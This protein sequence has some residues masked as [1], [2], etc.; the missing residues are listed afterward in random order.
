MSSPLT[1]VLGT[2]SK[3]SV[4]STVTSAKD[5]QTAITLQPS[6]LS[7]PSS[8]GSQPMQWLGAVNL[9]LMSRLPCCQRHNQCMHSQWLV[10][11][12]SAHEK[13]PNI[14][15]P[16]YF[17]RG[18]AVKIRVTYPGWPGHS[19]L[20]AS[21]VEYEFDWFASRQLRTSGPRQDR[22]RQI[23]ESCG[24]ADTVS[25]TLFVPLQL[26]CQVLLLFSVW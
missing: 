12:L 7:Y 16:L 3:Y 19:S 17:E 18:W 25:R 15:E 1:S 4:L 9:G 14:I 23:R 5:H 22:V 21:G 24:Q 2:P 20:S 26:A 6:Q 13:I 10:C 8:F 11:R